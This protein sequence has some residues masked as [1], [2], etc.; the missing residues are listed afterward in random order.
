MADAPALAESVNT[1]VV[2]VTDA[3][4]LPCQPVRLKLLFVSPLTVTVPSYTLLIDPIRLPVI[5]VSDAALMVS[6]PSTFTIR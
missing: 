5:A 4:S 6:V 3:P 2:L 1:P